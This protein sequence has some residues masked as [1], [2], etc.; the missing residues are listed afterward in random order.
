M[1]SVAIGGSDAGISG[2]LRAPSSVS[3]VMS[4]L[5][6]RTRIPISRSV[7]HKCGPLNW[8]KHKEYP[9]RDSNP[10]FRRERAAS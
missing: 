4:R 5:L 2:A 8:V 7:A 9:Q 6:S 3:P 1:Y 10:C